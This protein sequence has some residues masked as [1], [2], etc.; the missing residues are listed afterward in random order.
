MLPLVVGRAGCRGMGM[1]TS[2]EEAARPF[3]RAPRRIQRLYAQPTAAGS[4]YH[5]AMRDQWHAVR[6]AV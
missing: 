4:R 1:M 2:T 5:A 3:K 6:I